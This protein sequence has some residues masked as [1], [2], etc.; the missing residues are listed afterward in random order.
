MGMFDDVLENVGEPYK[1]GGKGF[2]WG[3]HEVIIGEAN[4]VQKKTKANNDSAVIEVVVFDEADNDR[5]A[6]CT[7]YFHTE[8]G[9]KMAVTKVLGLLVHKVDDSKKDA[10]R[11]LGKKLFGSIDDPIK[12]RDVAVKLINDKLIGAKAFLVVEPQGKYKTSS[13]GDIWHYPA[14]PESDAPESDDPLAGATPLSKEEAEA[15]PDFPDD[16]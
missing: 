16:L 2:P 12:A 8:G 1:G 14:V 6:T 13:Y 10:V 4:A 3:T 5:T 7:L 9:A 15:A 11:E